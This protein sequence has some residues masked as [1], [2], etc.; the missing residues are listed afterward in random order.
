MAVEIQKII[1]EI[2]RFKDV[3]FKGIIGTL[4]YYVETVRDGFHGLMGHRPG[5]GRI[6]DLAMFALMVTT[7]LLILKPLIKFLIKLT[8]LSALS[9]LVIGY[10]QPLPAAE[11]I[12][13]SVA[14]GF[15]MIVL[16]K[17]V[18]R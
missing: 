2:V 18:L 9:A 6:Y 3:D 4:A 7:P 16:M 17:V 14:A 12:K 10:L 8:A 13:V 11:L 5:E 15:G 1:D